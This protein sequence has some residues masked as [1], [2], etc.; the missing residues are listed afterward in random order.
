MQINKS[1]HKWQP[2]LLSSLIK[3][4]G[5][6]F[7]SMVVLFFP[8]WSITKCL[9]FSCFIISC[10]ST[11]HLMP[12]TEFTYTYKVLGSCWFATLTKYRMWS[13]D[14][15]RFKLSCESSSGSCQIQGNLGR[16]EYCVLLYT[17]NLFLY[18]INPNVSYE[19]WISGA[20][21]HGHGILQCNEIHLTFEWSNVKFTFLLDTEN[22][23]NL[24]NQKKSW[25]GRKL[26][27]NG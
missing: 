24:S 21:F 19:P 8:I 1:C 4:L 9:M 18:T 22:R 27:Q 3:T 6:G 15:R 26:K 12:R 13:P 7:P 17:P 11:N 25:A 5:N 14:K 10:W 2:Q 20:I 16:R 23:E